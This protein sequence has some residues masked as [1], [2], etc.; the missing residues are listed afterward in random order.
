MRRQLVSITRDLSL[1][2]HRWESNIAVNL[3]Y[4]KQSQLCVFLLINVMVAQKDASEINVC[5]ICESVH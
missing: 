3:D 2:P 1:V 4:P 5:I